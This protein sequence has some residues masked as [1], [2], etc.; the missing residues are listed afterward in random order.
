MLDRPERRTFGDPPQPAV[1]GEVACRLH[2]IL[3]CD[4]AL[5]VIARDI[6]QARLKPAPPAAPAAF[7][8]E[9]PAPEFNRLLSGQ[10]GGEHRIGGF[11]QVMAF[12]EDVA[13]HGW[14]SR[15]PRRPKRARRVR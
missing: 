10:C 12:V 3:D 7:G 1:A 11:E 14:R 5:F 4:A 6:G 8:A 13:A 15:C 2:R 9:N